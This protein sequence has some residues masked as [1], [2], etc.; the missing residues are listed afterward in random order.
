MTRTPARSMTNAARP[1][2]FGPRARLWM[3]LCAAVLGM[4]AGAADAQKPVK[5]LKAPKPLAVTA[6]PDL[7]QRAKPV[8]AP[9]AH[10]TVFSDRARIVR[11]AVVPRGKTGLRT[12]RL[13]SLPGAT[14]MDTLRVHA[15]GARVIRLEARPQRG[16][17]VKIDAIETLLDDIEAVRDRMAAVDAERNVFQKEKEM[18]RKSAYPA[19]LKSESERAAWETKSS[20]WS[21]SLDFVQTRLSDVDQKLAALDGRT[22]ALRKELGRLM[23]VLNGYQRGG[24]SD[25]RIEVVAIL[26]ASSGQPNVTVQYDIRGATWTPQYTV[27]LSGDTQSIT[28]KSAARVQQSTGED[29]TG[30]KLSLSTAIPGQRMEL[31]EL[32]T[33]TLGEKRKF[34]PRP[35]A[36]RPTYPRPW[37]APNPAPTVGELRQA[38]RMQELDQR[39]S[40]A[41]RGGP[42]MDQVA[43]G[44]GASGAPGY[45]GG[46]G[47]GSRERR[48]PPPMAR[49]AEKGAYAFDDDEIAEEDL[50]V[51]MAMP[52]AEP[53][54]VMASA[55]MPKRARRSSVRSRAQNRT[56]LALFEPERGPRLTDPRLPAVAA[57][58]LDYVYDAQT[59][60][61][62][63][64]S[65]TA[66][67]VPL[68]STRFP[69]DV[70]YEASPG[71]SSTAYLKARVRNNGKNPLLR[72]PVRLFS[73][74][75]YV[76]EGT[77]ETT[78]PGG[79]LAFDLGAD[80]D[81]RI[82]R[83]VL[84]K[85]ATEGM[86][87]REDV[88]EY[89]TEI[90]V[91]NYKSRAIRIELTDQLPKSGHEDIKVELVR[92]SQKPMA[93]P[94]ADGRV[95]F[96]VD[97]AAGQVK[98]VQLVYRIRRPADWKLRQR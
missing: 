27:E 96:S 92:Y 90:E 42:S 30:V 28:L 9:I 32:L 70:F 31:P 24:L 20:T 91:G 11:K 13:P 94:D 47:R 21:M 82:K 77:L 50:A 8:A 81:V 48:P 89:T 4:H 74:N 19:P 88:T 39:V 95:R 86:F 53:A 80:E 16:T 35:R 18:L 41:A 75:S 22:K 37:P 59:R 33:W 66:H 38:L 72:G 76:G 64:S 15:K 84:P 85:T 7:L 12:V 43:L 17:R 69:V 68:S 36:E 67:V 87:A 46:Y 2:S 52:A 3:G 23:R 93:K 51:D 58:G 61:S 62:V 45:A 29:W 57:G 63:P 98:T 79:M 40:L 54:S 65:N 97:L 71:I 26:D 49:P 25:R 5:A 78:G 1:R 60:A 10:T 6:G 14:L 83:R 56:S 73:A 44:S 55:P 34:T